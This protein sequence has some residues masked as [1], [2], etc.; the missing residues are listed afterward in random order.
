MARAA[1]DRIGP[2]I[3]GDTVVAAWLRG[4][5]ESRRPEAAVELPAGG[6]TML[7]RSAFFLLFLSLAA[8]PALAYTVYLK[9][10]S[11]VLAKEKYT[12]QGDQAIITLPG[13]TKTSLPLSEIDVART[14]SANVVDYGDARVVEGGQVRQLR[15]QEE[16]APRKPTL[17]DLARGSGPR[18]QTARRAPES[19]TEPGDQP[20]TPAGFV[21]MVRLRRS[22]LNDI[23]LASDVTQF[24]RGQGVEELTIYQGTQ[25]DR[26]LLEVTANSEAAVFRAIEVAA[27]AF[28]QAHE[29]QPDK[30]AALE[31]FLTN[32]RRQ[33]AGQF[34]IDT[35]RANLLAS[36]RMDLPHF[37]LRYVEF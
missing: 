15:D 3:G 20:R 22:P 32:H 34:T 28:L 18:E 23:G 35:E 37:F 24:F 17:T 7:R 8:L 13:G 5:M 9:D 29:R 16:Q 21:D 10:G 30:L 1:G 27:N 14:E 12:V 33:R 2:V 36:K 26:V 6:A 25:P 11:T 31:L 19:A 4:I